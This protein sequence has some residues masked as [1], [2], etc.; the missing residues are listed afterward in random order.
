MLDK[1][2]KFHAGD[3]SA[4]ANPNYNDKDWETI[5]P[6]VDVKHIPQFQK[7]SFG[8]FRMKLFIDSNQFNEPLAIILSQVGA[9]E[10]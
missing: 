1:G 7:I 4:W 5:N 8:W 10:I 2:W 3:D 9:S 6:A